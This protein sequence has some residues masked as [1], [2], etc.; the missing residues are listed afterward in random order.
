MRSFL[1]VA[2]LLLTTAC[3]HGS[4]ESHAGVVVV[5]G[6]CFDSSRHDAIA[7]LIIN[8]TNGP[9]AF[10]A[11]GTSGPPYSLHPRA[12]DVV[13]ADS[14]PADPGSWS[15]LLEEFAPPDHQ[16]RLGTGDRAEFRAYT[17]RW[18]MSAYRGKVKLHVRDTHGHLH[19]S[20]PVPV[21]DHGS[22]PGNGV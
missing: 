16:V 10:P 17:S 15:V 18:P 8:G 22:A 2:L 4:P 11:S 3:A 1:A 19:E 13:A 6:S 14:T 12:F 9:V 21:C 5:P 20:D 7:V